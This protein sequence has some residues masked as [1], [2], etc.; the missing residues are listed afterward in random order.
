[1]GEDV[2]EAFMVSVDVTPI[3][4]EVMAPSLEGMNYSG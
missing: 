2:F 1:L 4:D 3:T